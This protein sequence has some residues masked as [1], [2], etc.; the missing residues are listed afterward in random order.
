MSKG[1]RDRSARE[2]LADERRLQEQRDRR[3]RR[4]GVI[5]GAVTLIGAAVVIAVVVNGHRGKSE[6]GY[7]GTIAPASRQADGSIVMARPGV[8]KPV[9]EIFEDFQCPA[10]QNFE[11]TSSNTI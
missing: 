4:F 5:G 1:T 2:R 6:A 8:T 9:M 3:N 10:C 7:A 11:K